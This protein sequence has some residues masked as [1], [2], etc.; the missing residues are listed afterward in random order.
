MEAAEALGVAF[1]HFVWGSE[2]PSAAAGPLTIAVTDAMTKMDRVAAGLQ[3]RVWL[4]LRGGR[5]DSW[6]N[7]PALYDRKSTLTSDPQQD[8]RGFWR[9]V[10][11]STIAQPSGTVCPVALFRGFASLEEALACIRGTGLSYH[12]VRD[13]RVGRG[14]GAGLTGSVAG[15]SGS[16]P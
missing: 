14:S 7:G 16:S 4:V 13:L 5:H 12:A 10:A 9:R 2:E 3:H 8:D 11:L 6:E 15:S 1:R